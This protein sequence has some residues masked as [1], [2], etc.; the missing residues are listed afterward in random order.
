M[1]GCNLKQETN[2]I[3]PL[4]F[5]REK[6]AAKE[7][8]T[9]RIT[10]LLF[11]FITIYYLHIRTTRIFVCKTVKSRGQRR[12]GHVARTCRQEKYIEF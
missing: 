7:L 4:V 9:H 8:Y 12:V 1:L 11:L 5:V 10:F 6:T 2:I 3:L